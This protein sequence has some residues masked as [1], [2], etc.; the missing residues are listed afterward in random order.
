MVQPLT[1]KHTLPIGT[2]SFSAEKNKPLVFY[3]AKAG[4][5]GNIGMGKDNE[6]KEFVIIPVEYLEK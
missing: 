4:H 3:T 5:R 6:G 2:L 1:E